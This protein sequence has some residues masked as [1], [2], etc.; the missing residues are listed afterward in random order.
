MKPMQDLSGRLTA[1]CV[2]RVGK[3]FAFISTNWKG[4]ESR[5]LGTLAAMCTVTCDEKAPDEDDRR[6][7]K[8]SFDGLNAMSKLLLFSRRFKKICVVNQFALHAASMH[9]PNW[10]RVAG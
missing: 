4:Q 7:P 1:F 10:C 8:A 3:L 5:M 6:Y 2:F 9:G